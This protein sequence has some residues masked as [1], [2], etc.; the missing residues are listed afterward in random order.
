M[1]VLLTG[2][3]LYL[4]KMAQ[5]VLK[6]FFFT[7][8]FSAPRMVL[9]PEDSVPSTIIESFLI[10]VNPSLYRGISCRLYPKEARE[11]FK[12]SS[13]FQTNLKDLSRCELKLV[14]QLDFEA[15]SAFV[16]K[17]VAEVSKLF[18]LY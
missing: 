9:V 13:G 15:K 6:E 18:I 5:K 8:D 4:N 11:F 2:V 1:N 12:L 14:K 7:L 16:L 10:R 17:I 3:L